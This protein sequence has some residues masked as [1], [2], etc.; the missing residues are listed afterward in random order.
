MS[1]SSF[2]KLGLWSLEASLNSTELDG[3]GE[4]VLPAG[5][6]FGAVVE[7]LGATPAQIVVERAMYWNAS[8]VIWAAGSNLLATKLQ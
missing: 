4:S 3:F 7:S 6:R 2:G 8:G 1:S 5:T